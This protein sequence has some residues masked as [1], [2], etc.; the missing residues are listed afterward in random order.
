MENKLG[1]RGPTVYHK[2]PISVTKQSAPK[3]YQCGFPRTRG[4]EEPVAENPFGIREQGVLWQSVTHSQRKGDVLFVFQ[5]R[6]RRGVWPVGRSPWTAP[7]ASIL[8]E[9]FEHAGMQVGKILLGVKLL[10]LRK[11]CV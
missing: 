3:G 6:N 9:D 11:P 4:K 7:R 5:R 10:Q 1:F 2:W 8:L